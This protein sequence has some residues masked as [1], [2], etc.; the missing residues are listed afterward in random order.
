MF[1]LWTTAG[2]IVHTILSNQSLYQTACLGYTEE[3][4]KNTKPISYSS[5]IK[6][7]KPG[8]ER[9]EAKVSNTKKS[10]EKE[11]EI[12]NSYLS[13]SQMKKK[14]DSLPVSKNAKRNRNDKKGIIKANDYKHLTNAP[15]KRCH[16]CGNKNHLAIDC[17]LNSPKAHSHKIS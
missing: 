9:M 17:K 8:G 3:E 15:R 6:Y 1:K 12:N 5:P 16:K 2:R 10:S 4:D 7:V 13:K 14:L 11:K